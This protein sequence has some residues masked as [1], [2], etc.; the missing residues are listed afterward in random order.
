MPDKPILIFPAATVAARASLPQAFPPRAPRPTQSQQ[1]ERLAARFQALSHQFGAVQTD[2]TGVDP[3]QVIVLETVGSLND[4]QNV[5]RRIRGMEWLGDFDVDVVADDAGFLADGADA[6]TVEGR[7]F[8]VATNRT[9]YDELLRLWNRWTQSRDEKLPRNYGA[10]A[11]AF[12]YLNDVR[13][14]S[15]RDRVEATG[16][17]LSWEA[18]LAAN[19]PTIRFEAELWCRAT[20]SLRDLAYQRFAATVTDAGG[21]CI[22]QVQI[23]DINYHGVLLELPAPAVREAVD[24]LNDSRDTRLLRLSDVKYFAPMGQAS[25][26]SIPEGVPRPA[27]DRPLPTGN[28]IAALLDGLPLSNHA[29]L[30][31]RLRIDDP[32][33][34]A[35]LYRVGEHR[36]GT[37]MASLIAHG[38]LDADEPPLNSPIYVRPVMHPGE[39]DIHGWRIEVFPPDRLAVDVIHRAVRRIAEGDGDL[40]AQAPTV[41]IVNLSLGDSA[42]PFDRQLSPW[43]RLLDWL[44]WKYRL[45]FIVSAG[46]HDDTLMIPVPPGAVADLSDED[47]RAHVLRAM[48]HQRVARRLLAPAESVNALTVGC[49]HAQVAPASPSG[50]LLDPLRG[51]ALPSPISTVASGF[52]RAIKPEILVPGGL[53]HYAP[54][55][56]QPSKTAA[57]FEIINV[58]NQPGQLVATGGGNAVPPA[59]EGRVSGTSNAAA[60]TTRRGVQFAEHVEQMRAEPDGT[61]LDES[62]LAVILKAMLV[63]GASWGEWETVFDQVFDGPDDGE[64]PRRRIKRACAQFLGYGPADFE[65][66]TVCSD[67]RVILLGVGELRVDEGHVYDVPLPPA[68]HAMKERR[69]LT[70]TLAWLSPIEPTHRSYRVADLWFD[71]PKVALRVE[72]TDADYRAV[73]RGTIQHEVLEGDA[74]VPIGDNDT[75]P[76]QVN[77]KASTGTKLKVAVPYALMVSLETARPLAVSIYEQVKVALDRIRTAARV[78]PAIRPL[79]S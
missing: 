28:P 77:C 37:A 22:T 45:L 20:P 42:Q 51:A 57:E 5:V 74:A 23:A 60:L 33:N 63:H 61:V 62:R 39:P 30:Q 76:I 55:I 68:L 14:W 56:V 67:Q 3:E 43:A 79:R 66:G 34:F 41:R 70:I 69:R 7:L 59:H 44:A 27:V 8:V 9:A 46:N 40:P 75:M 15:A 47:L 17:V 18:G 73:K 50:R 2:A 72:R 36:H 1:R 48:A 58:A 53:R 38:E 12:K 21:Q 32:D 54:K 24:A 52:R 10:L 29:V 26:V 65:R 16:V 13:P 25:I 11:E 4:F 64:Q 6:S 19:I 35:S 78:R 71:P 31:D 49:L